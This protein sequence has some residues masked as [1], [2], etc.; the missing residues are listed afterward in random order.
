MIQ[1][2]LLFEIITS[3]NKQP[4]QQAAYDNDRIIKLSRH[5]VCD[6]FIAIKTPFDRDADDSLPLQVKKPVALI[7]LISYSVVMR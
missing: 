2:R 1:S 3:C 5:L 7:L 6:V 4:R